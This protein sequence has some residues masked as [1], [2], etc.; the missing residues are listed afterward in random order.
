MS[1]ELQKRYLDLEKMVKEVNFEKGNNAELVELQVDLISDL[2]TALNEKQLTMD[3]LRN[4]RDQTQRIST[5]L[6]KKVKEE[7]KQRNDK[8]TE[9]EEKKKKGKKKDAK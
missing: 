8:E 3:E 7:R 4:L 1:P 2:Q 6:V 5:L 9:E